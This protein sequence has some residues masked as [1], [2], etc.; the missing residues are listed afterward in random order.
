MRVDFL[1]FEDPA[2][3]GSID[4]DIYI[5]MQ[6]GCVTKND[7]FLKRFVCLFVMFYP[8]FFKSRK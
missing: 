5:T 8:H 2:A 6:C 1:Y 7:H 3:A 4:D